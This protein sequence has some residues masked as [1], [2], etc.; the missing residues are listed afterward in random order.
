MLKS[1]SFS[2]LILF[3]WLKVILLS[4]PN[5]NIKKQFIFGKVCNLEYNTVYL[6]IHKNCLPTN[7]YNF[8]S[9]VYL[10]LTIL[11]HLCHKSRFKGPKFYYRKPCCCIIKHI[12]KNKNDS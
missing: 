8:N 9:K 6:M 12:P 11:V 5:K 7:K 4:N 2:W 1:F 3:F 10:N